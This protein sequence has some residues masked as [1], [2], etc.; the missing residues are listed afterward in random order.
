MPYSETDMLK[1]IHELEVAQLE[2][3]LQNEEL[4]LAKKEAETEA[5]KYSELYDFAPACYLTLSK[6][7]KIIEINQ[8]GSKILGKDRIHLKNSSF[9]FSVSSSTRLIFSLFLKDAFDTKVKQECEVI[10][11]INGIETKKV[12]LT[13]ITT[14]SGE[15]CL[16]DLVDIT[17]QKRAE[18]L[19]N[20]ALEKA[21][22]GNR[23]KTAFINNISHEVR[24]PLNGILG[25]SNLIIEPDIAYEDK[26]QYASYIKTNCNRLL[27]T[28]TNYIDI[29]MIVSGTLIAKFELFDL[30]LVL[31]QIYGQFKP[32]CADKNIELH[33]EIPIENNPI[34]L[35]SDIQLFRKI[36]SHILD[37]AIRQTHQGVIAFGFTMQAGGIRFFV[38]DTGIGIGMTPP[39]QVFE[40]FNLEKI[41]PT[42]G[43][44]GSGLGLSVAYGFV[45]LLG[46]EMEVESKEGAGSTFFFTFPS[47]QMG[48]KLITEEKVKKVPTLAKPV[49]LIAEDDEY[50]LF[51]MKAIFRGENVRIIT[52]FNG[53]EA[54]ECCRANPDISVVLMD[55]RMPVLD[56]LDATLEIRSFRKDLPIIA[57][58][59]FAFSDSESKVYAAGC[60]DYLTKPVTIEALLEKLRKYGVVVKKK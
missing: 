41:L 45:Q 23:F 59:A 13:G 27:N 3:K 49:I 31:N 4:L 2:L 51:Y 43:H 44:E 10:L 19:I 18:T 55:I 9:G 15:E 20:E 1:I 26:V 24:T 17:D 21:E 52:V 36:L 32:L 60:N 7:G 5:G 38:R 56:G 53:E 35:S 58:T 11:L 16:V 48:P 14:S 12:R 30:L 8:A 40:S 50:A 25:F 28:I 42:E 29:S 47:H 22:S 57:L 54:V 33:L 37:N 46:G 6:E 39:S 34:T